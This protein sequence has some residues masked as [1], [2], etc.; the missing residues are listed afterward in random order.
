MRYL[1]LKMM[2]FWTVIKGLALQVWTPFSLNN[3]IISLPEEE[4]VMVKIAESKINL[5][6]LP[7]WLKELHL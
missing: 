3:I 5:S 2:D 6:D 7:N 1:L 4:T